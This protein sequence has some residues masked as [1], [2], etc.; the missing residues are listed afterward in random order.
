MK[1]VLLLSILALAACSSEKEKIILSFGATSE[2]FD[3]VTEGTNDS[4]AVG[5]PGPDNPFGTVSIFADGKEIDTLEF[6]GAMRILGSASSPPEQIS[7]EGTTTMDTYF[8]VSRLDE[9]FRGILLKKGELE[10]GDINTTLN[11]NPDIKTY[12]VNQSR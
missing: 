2:G 8:G 12:E 5:G 3:S 7:F 4:F 6:G 1:I 9:E 10:A 11:W